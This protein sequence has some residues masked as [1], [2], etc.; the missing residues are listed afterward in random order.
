V[1]APNPALQI[2]VNKKVKRSDEGA[3][4]GKVLD[5]ELFSS[6]AELKAPRPKLV[7]V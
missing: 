3:L 7:K 4:S 2:R 6:T 1:V 5:N